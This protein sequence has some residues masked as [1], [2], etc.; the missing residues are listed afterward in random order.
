MEEK[1]ITNFRDFSELHPLKIKRDGVLYIDRIPSFIG[2]DISEVIVDAAE[3]YAYIGTLLTLVKDDVRILEQTIK[4]DEN[5]LFFNIKNKKIIKESDSIVRARVKT[6]AELNLKKEQLND[7]KSHRDKMQ[8]RINYLEWIRDMF[9]K[10]VTRQF[11]EQLKTNIRTPQR[12]EDV[13]KLEDL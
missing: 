10:G 1:I 9:K 13:L 6:N 2:K 12:I 7:L 3:E 5:V 4:N 11:K 8:V